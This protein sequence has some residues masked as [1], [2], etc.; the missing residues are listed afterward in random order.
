MTF[1][2]VVHTGNWGQPNSDL[3]VWVSRRPTEPLEQ[4]IDA[5]QMIL[6]QT[7]GNSAAVWDM[8]QLETYMTNKSTSVDH[9]PVQ[10]WYDDLIISSQ[11]IADPVGSLPPAPLEEFIPAAPPEDLIPP[12]SPTNIAIQIN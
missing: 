8:I 7:S 10:T 2:W 4:I 11:P 1:Y 12:A 6:Q 3:E 9:T 5:H